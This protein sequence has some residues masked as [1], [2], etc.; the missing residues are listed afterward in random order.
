MIQMEEERIPKKIL[1]TEM[2]EKL[3][4]GTPRTGWIDQIRK[5]I[6]MRGENWEETQE[7]RK[8]ENRDG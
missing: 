2:E 5:N 1:H 8:W 3:P 6:E 7:N 4:K